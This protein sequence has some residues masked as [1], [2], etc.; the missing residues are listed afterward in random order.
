[1]GV[2]V[3]ALELTYDNLL[4]KGEQMG[5]GLCSLNN[6]FAI[7]LPDDDKPTLEFTIDEFKK[8][9]KTK[10]IEKHDYF[11]DNN[12]NDINIEIMDAE[13]HFSMFPLQKKRN[14]LQIII[15]TISNQW[16]RL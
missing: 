4:S 13:Q 9:F 7:L 2:T 11:A 5:N 15:D 14:T 16:I 8:T 12:D 1:M 6:R 10:F 3:K